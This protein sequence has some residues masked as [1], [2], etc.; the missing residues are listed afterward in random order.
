M[1]S[2]R[3][4]SRW[5]IVSGTIRSGTTFAGNIL[6]IPKEVS[7]LHEPFNG[8]IDTRKKLPFE[9]KYVS[10][11]HNDFDVPNYYSHLENIF[12]LELALPTTS[13][14]N[15]S[16]VRTLIKQ[17]MGSRG[18]IALKW[19]KVNP[20]SRIGLIK[21]PTCPLTVE[22]LYRA[23]NVQPV[24]IVRHPASLAAS[25]KRVQWWPQLHDFT[26]RRQIIADH[27]SEE[28]EFFQRVW[29]SPLMESM[30]HWRATYKVLLSQAEAFN[31]WIFLTHEEISQNP[32]HCFRWLYDKLNLNWSRFSNYAIERLT[33]SRNS[34][35]A[36][37]N[38]AMVLSRD[39]R[40]IFEHRLQS[41]SEQERGDIYD[42]V[43]DVSDVFYD[44]STY[45]I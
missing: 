6:S 7:Y 15:D 3:L 8:G 1:P 41:L 14:T 35:E 11:V 32:V 9:S 30:A 39:S 10:N 17:T 2:L 40:T 33:S 29:E 26:R 22:Y 13:H 42:I 4:P 25:L 31:D 18:P 12:R 34:A 21:D 44:P 37:N 20:F 19:A 45:K 43:K 28:P 27:F 24:I 23:F 16:S 5:I 36:T 38:Q